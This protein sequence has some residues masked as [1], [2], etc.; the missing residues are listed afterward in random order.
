M[1]LKKYQYESSVHPPG[2]TDLP[3]F[4]VLRIFTLITELF[5][6]VSFA[7]QFYAG[8]GIVILV[9]RLVFNICSDLALVDAIPN[10][11]SVIISCHDPDAYPMI[12]LRRL[13]PQC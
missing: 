7:E 8:S 5:L 6:I 10:Q 3:N 4:C 1:L 13:L 11:I 2:R 9:I 12:F